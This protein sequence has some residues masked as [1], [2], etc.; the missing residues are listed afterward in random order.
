MYLPFMPPLAK[1]IVVGLVLVI[2]A[3]LAIGMWIEAVEEKYKVNLTV[4]FLM[5]KVIGGIAAIM[6]FIGSL[7]MVADLD[8]F[9]RY[10]GG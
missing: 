2:F 9:V 4:A 6:G 3:S 1:L 5:I 8:G 7:W 10:F